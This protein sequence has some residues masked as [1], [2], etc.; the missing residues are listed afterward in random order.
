MALAREDY[1]RPVGFA[2]EP[3]MERRRW[4]SRIVLAAFVA[5]I[6]WLLINRVISP[7]DDQPRRVTPTE[8]SLPG[9]V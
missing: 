9:P 4:V 6:G 7:P 2:R 5:L 8:S 3:A 1:T